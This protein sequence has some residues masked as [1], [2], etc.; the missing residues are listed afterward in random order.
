MGRTRTLCIA[1]GLLRPRNPQPQFMAGLSAPEKEMV[2]AIVLGM[3][4]QP[5]PTETTEETTME[6]VT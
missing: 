2:C 6:V 5:P 4:Q 3:G 1:L